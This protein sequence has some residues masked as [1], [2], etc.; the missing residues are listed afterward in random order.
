MRRNRRCTIHICITDNLKGNAHRHLFYIYEHF[1][2]TSISQNAAPCIP[3][4]SSKR[5]CTRIS[6]F[7]RPHL[8]IIALT[9]P[10]PRS[11]TAH[12]EFLL[13]RFCSKNKTCF[14]TAP[15]SLFPKPK[16]RVPSPK[17]NVPCA[18]SP[19]LT[20]HPHL[21]LQPA[22]PHPSLILHPLYTRPSQLPSGRKLTYQQ[23]HTSTC[24]A[25]GACAVVRRSCSIQS[26]PLRRGGLRWFG[27]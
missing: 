16:T 25:A 3:N 23:D 10:R 15:I 2:P 21:H 6:E 22:P 5:S 4:T 18:V 20:L 8:L 19:L 9:H 7:I 12:H 1:L 14:R 13:P 11:S 26:V 17:P 24:S 27:I